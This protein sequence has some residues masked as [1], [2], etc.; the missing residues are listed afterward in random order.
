MQLNIRLGSP[1]AEFIGQ[2][3]VWSE[4]GLVKV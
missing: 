3:M 2:E 1:F 4:R